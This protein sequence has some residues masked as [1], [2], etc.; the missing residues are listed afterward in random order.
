MVRIK[1][2]NDIYENVIVENNIGSIRTSKKQRIISLVFSIV[3]MAL[4]LEFIIVYPLIPTIV[5]I[6]AASRG[7]ENV[8]MANMTA[9]MNTFMSFIGAASGFIPGVIG[10][11]LGIKSNNKKAYVFS[12]I[13]IVLA[14]ILFIF[15][16]SAAGEF[17][18]TIN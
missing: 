6:E 11:I 2:E 7:M 12:I 17:V 4:A 3:G 18:K 15:G 5:Q 13:A 16:I 1:M 8:D 9:F 14:V 10:L